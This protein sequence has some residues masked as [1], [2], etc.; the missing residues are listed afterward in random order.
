MGLQA[1]LSHNHGC[2]IKNLGERYGFVRQDCG[3]CDVCR[4]SPTA[5]LAIAAKSRK[6]KDNSTMNRALLVLG[7]MSDGCLY[8]ESPSC[9]QEKCMAKNDRYCRGGSHYNRNCANQLTAK[10]ILEG[11]ACYDCFDL[12]DRNGYTTHI[13]EERPLKRRLPCMVFA[14]CKQT[15]VDFET[16]PTAKWLPFI[17]SSIPCRLPREFSTIFAF[18]FLSI[19]ANIFPVKL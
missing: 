18:G 17:P 5:K 8:C 1:W 6:S 12:H 2:R 16:L 15:G 11:K 19:V 10:R 4:G 9:D 7:R 13:K 3:F 14:R